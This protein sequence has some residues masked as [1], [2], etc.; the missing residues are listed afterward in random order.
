MTGDLLTAPW[1]A[2]DDGPDALVRPPVLDAD[3][4]ILA[5]GDVHGRAAA[6]NALITR[7]AASPC[8]GRRIVAFVGD[9]IDRGP[10]SIR[11]IET[12]LDA[13]ARLD[14]ERAILLPGNHELMAL[15][16]IE[17]PGEHGLLWLRNGGDAVLEEAE[18]RVGRSARTRSELPDLLK[19]ALPAAW[20]AAMAQAPGAVEIGRVLLVH[21]GVDPDRP[22]GEA[23]A[24]SPSRHGHARHWAWIREPFLDHKGGW[25]GRLVVHGHTPLF[26]DRGRI[27]DA[28]ALERAM[29]R[30]P[31]RGRINLDVGAAAAD[32]IGFTQIRSDRRRVGALQF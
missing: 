7:L 2:F 18:R 12:A 32:R 5:I 23:L 22:L 17:A 14:A 4:E 10:E 1:R 13:G 30:A 15:D 26:D 9:L 11:A 29:D 21:A 28:E 27:T 25:G 19:E 6:L 16:E 31:D 8:P 20:F 3:L 24:E